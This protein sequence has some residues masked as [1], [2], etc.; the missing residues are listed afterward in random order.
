M[1]LFSGKEKA[2]KHKQI[3]PVTARVRGV[4]RPGGQ[5][6]PERWP[7]VKSLYVLCVEPKEHKHFRPGTRPGGF[8]RGACKRGLR[9]LGHRTY[10]LHSNFI[11]E[12]WS[13]HDC[14]WQQC[15]FSQISRDK[16]ARPK[17]ASC[18]NHIWAITLFG[19]AR[20]TPARFAEY[21][22]NLPGIH[23]P[24]DFAGSAAFVGHT[25]GGS[26]NSE[27]KARSGN[28][29]SKDPFGHERKIS[30]KRKFWGRI[31]RGHS[32]GICADIPAQN[33]GQGAQ[34]PGKKQAFGRG[35]PWPEGANVHDPKGLPKTSVRKTLGWI[36]VPY[37]EETFWEPFFPWKPRYKTPTENPSANRSRSD[38][39]V[40]A[41]AN[42]DVPRNS[43]AN[44][45]RQIPE[46]KLRIN[47]V[48]AAN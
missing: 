17:C 29:G 37:L 34:N 12:T 25:P 30:P 11:P 22:K 46:K 15:V 44:Y 24:D 14:H 36:F 21:Q 42:S 39:A 31:S 1:R 9:K 26:S 35:H 33:F 4:S 6:S 40:N 10:Q 48:S 19:Q 13:N 23:P 2:H 3:L 28:P 8:G 38:A 43:L 32:G 5:G 47:I 41:N 45:G 20:F 7:G 27:F 18:M 16:N